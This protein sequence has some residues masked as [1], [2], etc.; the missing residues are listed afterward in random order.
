MLSR[1]FYCSPHI[2]KPS[3]R[4]VPL[5]VKRISPWIQLFTI[6]FDNIQWHCNDFCNIPQKTTPLRKSWREMVLILANDLL[7][8]NR[9]KLYLDI[10]KLIE[11]GLETVCSCN[12][13][14]IFL[15]SYESI[16]KFVLGNFLFTLFRAEQCSRKF[17][18]IFCALKAPFCFIFSTRRRK[19]AEFSCVFSPRDCPVF[20]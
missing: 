16:S 20:L 12:H 6:F 1:F 9:L 15:G 18:Q 14:K 2:K 17:L 11:S 3:V 4:Q 7:R 5:C 13:H 8:R 19:P 10:V